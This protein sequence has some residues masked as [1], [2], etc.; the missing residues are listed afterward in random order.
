MGE[1]TGRGMRGEDQVWRETGE[2]T[3]RMNGNS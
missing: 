2:R 1:G 3:R